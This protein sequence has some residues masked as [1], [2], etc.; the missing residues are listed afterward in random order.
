MVVEDRHLDSNPFKAR[1]LTTSQ[2]AAEKEYVP[3]GVVK[4]VIKHCPTLEWKLL[5]ALARTI[6]TRVR[7]EIEE[8]AWGDVD[9]ENNR[10]L[11]HSPKN[12]KREEICTTGADPCIFE[13]L[14]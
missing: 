14:P 1:G 9:W 10:M 12:R 4:A 13:A 6:P 3:W 5:F 11:I 8:L 2:T 7:S